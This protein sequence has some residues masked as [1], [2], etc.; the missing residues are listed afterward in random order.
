MVASENV[1]SYTEEIGDGMKE[2]P[3]RYKKAYAAELAMDKAWAIYW[4]TKLPADKR[5]YNRLVDVWYSIILDTL[6]M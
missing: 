5:R 3:K 6:E 4:A 1:K 2:V